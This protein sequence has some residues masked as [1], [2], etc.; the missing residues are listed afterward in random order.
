MFSPWSHH[1]LVDNNLDIR[2]L[3]AIAVSVLENAA[4]EGHSILP[5]SEFLERLQATKLETPLPV[6]G[7]VLS[8]LLR[9][10]FLKSELNIT[11]DENEEEI[12]FVKLKRLVEVKNLILQKFDI[13]NAIRQTYN[14]EK[15]WIKLIDNYPSS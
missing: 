11:W 2:R 6:T 3:R 10:E 9:D 13:D 5:F 4:L 12:L 8:S 1:S 14:I 15:E 7:D